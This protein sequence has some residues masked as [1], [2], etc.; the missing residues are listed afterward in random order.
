MRSLPLL[1]LLLLSVTLPSGSVIADAC[2]ISSRA[3]GVEVELCQENRSIPRELFRSG[4]CQPQLVDQQVAVRF[5][6]SCPNGAFGICRNAQAAN[7]AYRQDVH[8][9]GV[10]SDAR[11]LRPACEQQPGARWESPQR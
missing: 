10:A 7:L 6:A 1:L 11:F 9:Y 8:Y 5:V 3:K 4:Y 2:I